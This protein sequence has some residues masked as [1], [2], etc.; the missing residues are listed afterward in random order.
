MFIKEIDIIKDIKEIDTDEIEEE[1]I[2]SQLISD[3]MQNISKKNLKSLSEPIVCFAEEYLKLYIYSIYSCIVF[4][5]IIS[6]INT[7]LLI[8]R[9]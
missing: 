8:R 4:L 7:I 6:L 2:I 1:T 9:R 5:I 3:L